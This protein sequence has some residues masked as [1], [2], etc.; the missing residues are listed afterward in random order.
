MFK[1]I[2]AFA[3]L[4]ALLLS[5]Q[6]PQPASPETAEKKKFHL[7]VIVQDSSQEKVTLLEI[8]AVN[9]VSFPLM[10]KYRFCD[11]LKLQNEGPY[12]DA[13]KQSDIIHEKGSIGIWDSLNTDGF[14]IFAD[15]KTSVH[16]QIGRA[17]V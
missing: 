9:P 10:G 15:Y 14:Q 17:H 8:K 5:C 2:V 7:P 3:L 6:N 4:S 13:I 16:Y 1:P 11:T 12:M